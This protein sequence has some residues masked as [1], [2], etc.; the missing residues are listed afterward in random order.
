MAS[1]FAVAIWSLSLCVA[2]SARPAACLL[3]ATAPTTPIP[4]QVIV[5]A[6]QSEAEKIRAE[7][8]QGADFA[9]LAK[10]KSTDPSANNGGYM[11]VVDPASLR[12]EL[13]EAL[14]GVAP[15][16]LSPIVHLPSGF[17]ILKVLAAPPQTPAASSQQ[18]EPPRSNMGSA[19]TA[20]Q[21]MSAQGIMRN[22]ADVSGLNEAEA[23]LARFDKPTDWNQD[24]ATICKMRNESY[25]H[26]KSQLE[27]FLAGD[28]SASP[29][30]APPGGPRPIDRIQAIFGLGQLAAYQGDMNEAIAQYEKAATLAEQS[31]PEATPVFDETL[32][33]AYLHRSEVDN[34]IYRDPGDRCIFP[35]APKD[36]YSKT[37]DSAKAIQYF[38]R[39]L[40]QKPDELEVKWLLNIAYMTT[41]AYPSGVPPQYLLDPKLFESGENVGRFKDVAPAAG[42]SSFA[43]A[44]GVIVD[45]F[46]NDGLFDIVSSSM[47]MC[48]P[49]HYFH[50]NGDGTFT[51]RAAQAHLSDQLGGLNIIQAD[52]NNDGCTDI[53][54]LRGGWE[55][56]QRKSLL[57]NNC[58][59]TFT[60]VTK[61]AGLAEP[62]TSTQTAVWTDINNDG[63]LDLFVGSENGPA[64]LFLNNGDG[65]FKDIS[66]SAGIDKITYAKG[67]V[68]GD[69]DNDGWPDLYV[70]NF[71]GENLL[72][73]NNHDNTFTEVAHDAGVLGNGRGFAAFFLDY[74]NDGWP[75]IFVTSYFTSVDET[76]R[77]YL[78][79]PHNV[80]SLKLYRNLG[81][82]TFHDVTR[83]VGLNKVYMPMGGNFGDFDN[84][85][86][87]DI[88][89]G[90]GNPSY[91][92]LIP[93]VLLKNI[94]GKKFVDVTSSS[95]TGELHKGHGV[96]FADLE[97]NGKVDI[98]EEIGGAVPGDRHAFRLFENPG[99]DNDWITVKLV[100]VKSNRG[101]IGA[102]IHVTV[103][104]AGAPPREIYR[105]VNSGGSFGASPLEQHIGIGKSAHIDNIEI[106]WPT[107][108]TRQN[109]RNVD[110]NQFIQ[111]KEFDT[112]FTK[113]DRK[114]YHLGASAAPKP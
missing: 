49:L 8:R 65:T 18:A 60:D 5:V 102:R 73:H 69:Y 72:Y 110:S 53:L 85:G 96:A 16:G 52:Y 92:S 23:A 28:P 19:G 101:A 33:V 108:N 47:D 107:S 89:L 106:W 68:A 112:T 86:F 30:G 43:M 75:D 44:G 2:P 3:Q 58:D 32:G 93:N 48:Q 27:K 51:D 76:V 41:G 25:A 97:N 84:D 63:L 54:V 104:N 67:V 20:L 66:H 40:K 55:I 98:A 81:N 87:L 9:A 114:P 7:L 70:S 111:I 64:Q 35:M 21:A 45:D 103:E 10:D 88:Y 99:N 42:V 59:G 56:P 77:T 105:T 46:D 94:D 1:I 38:L 50:N 61:A 22:T 78:G 37:A 80:T 113:L 62:A 79:L 82:G 14:R 39:Y 100:G 36:K 74:D 90:T 26:A 24:P 17:T 109:F 34:N 12:P 4:L 57:K 6:S 15:G 11:G 71:Q 13:R 83:E 95:G 31:L 29:G 91:A